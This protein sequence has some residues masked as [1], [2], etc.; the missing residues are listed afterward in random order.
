LRGHIGELAL[1]RVPSRGV[2]APDEGD[3]YS[4]IDDIAKKYLDL[5]TPRKTFF[6]ATA[7]VEPFEKRD[8]I[9][10]AANHLQTVYDQAYFYTG[11]AFGITLCDFA[12]RG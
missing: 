10:A 9:E 2:F 1:K 12:A 6:A 8:K 11:L 4:E 7:G 3:L 5:A